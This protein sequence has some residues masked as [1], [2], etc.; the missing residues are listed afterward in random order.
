MSNDININNYEAYLLDYYEG[1][2]NTKFIEELKTFVIMHPELN[3][4]LE[5]SLIYIDNEPKEIINKT[6][7]Y[8]F[9]EDAIIAYVE[10]VA[11][12]NEKTK[13]NNSLQ[14]N[15]WLQK[16]ISLYQKTKL[17]P[18]YNITFNNKEKLKKRPVYFLYSRI[19]AAIVLFS[20]TTILIIYFIN[21]DKDLKNNNII[22]VQKPDIPKQKDTTT[23]QIHPQ[24][25][26]INKQTP[27]H[28]IN[29][30]NNKAQ[31]ITEYQKEQI[32]DTTTQIQNIEKDLV[33]NPNTEYKQI[34]IVTQT[35]TQNNTIKYSSLDSIPTDEQT[36]I[37]Q[38]NQ[39]L[40]GR[41]WNKIKTITGYSIKPTRVDVFY[42]DNRMIGINTY[43]IQKVTDY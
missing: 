13:I 2:L 16:E 32:K 1:R 11:T 17:Q 9:D 28:Q 31:H 27:K 4:D 7:L 37:V 34:T 39:K 41:I 21:K 5:H 33:I 14:D 42:N 26:V 18:D 40:L 29:N 10:D 38:N 35:V 8:K 24:N 3:I 36:P 20:V 25:F 12:D 19:A 23:I 22:L 6:T 30:N 15:A 43:T